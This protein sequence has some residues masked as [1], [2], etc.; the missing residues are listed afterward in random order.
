MKKVITLMCL[1]VLV[2]SCQAPSLD[3]PKSTEH[4]NTPPSTARPNPTEPPATPNPLARYEGDCVFC[5]ITGNEKNE[6]QWD[7][8]IQG[9]VYREDDP[10]EKITIDESFLV[11]AG[12]TIVF[13][14][15][16]VLIQPDKRK[17]I[18]VFGTLI[19]KDSLLLWQQ[20]EYQQTRLRVKKGGTLIIEDSYSFQGNPYWVNWEFEDGST[21]QFDHFIGDPWTSIR[22]SVNYTASNYSTVKMTF[23]NNVHDS[24]VKITD[25][26]HV[27]FE[28]FPPEGTYEISF[29][30]KRQ[31]FD[32][33]LS[34]MWPGTT[35]DVK[36]SYIYE[37]DI[38]IGNNTHITIKDTPSGF[39]LGWSISK[40]APGFVE[41]E[42]RNLGE[43]GNSNGILYENAVWD[44]PCNNSSLTVIN[45]R[46]QEAWPVIHGYIHLK[47]YDSNLA[48]P[49]NYE[50]PATM[51]IY[52]STI[53]IIAAYNGGLVYIEN[54]SIKDAIE[55]K[56]SRSIIYGFG[57]SGPY[58][59]IESDGGTYID[60]EEPG[61]PWD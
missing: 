1:A 12:E 21:V 29:P 60:L 43:P 15:E 58:S 46:L 35:V 4:P 59:L 45:S 8:S 47:I 56:D 31:W 28:I 38:S 42:I 7:Q 27:W 33:N 32:W 57:I 17:D 2:M 55:V 26:H 51:E 61:V 6:P 34:E 20:T 36:H 48:D 49:R 40:D 14:N 9:F 25:A 23:F 44:L 19:I 24:T 22:G 30:A 18:E 13:E 41:C 52:N 10:R 11:A 50:G 54:S 53:G 16:I 5:F 39:S 3:L 37:R